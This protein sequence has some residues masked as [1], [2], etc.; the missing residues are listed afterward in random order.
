MLG[1]PKD[2][3]NRYK[4]LFD[5][6]AN[7]EETGIIL[8]SMLGSSETS[9]SKWKCDPCSSTFANRT[10]Y[11]DHRRLKHSNAAGGRSLAKPNENAQKVWKCAHCSAGFRTKTLKL[12]HEGEQ[13]PL[14]VN[15]SSNN[16]VMTPMNVYPPVSKVRIAN[17]PSI[18]IHDDDSDN[19]DAFFPNI[20]EVNIDVDDENEI[21]FADQEPEMDLGLYMLQKHSQISGFDPLE[22]NNSNNSLLIPMHVYPSASKDEIIDDFNSKWKCRVCS[23]KFRTRDLLREHN[24]VHMVE[25]RNVKPCPKPNPKP[26]PKPSPKQLTKIKVKKFDNVTDGTASDKKPVV[27]DE[28]V[29]QDPKSRW[30]CK[31]CSLFFETR[32][33]LRIHRRNYFAKSESTE[34]KEELVE[35]PIKEEK[36]VLPEVRKVYPG[37]KKRKIEQPTV[38]YE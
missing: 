24:H 20:A 12:K 8:Q 9:P 21:V 29:L 34:V 10:Q 33:L 19:D 35:A 7:I 1:Q 32:E 18:L 26:S 17:E 25:K 6:E 4:Q 28:V 36:Q 22:V 37:A 30:Q 31:T 14:E 23:G 5:V 3:V 15:N 27:D 38:Q 16:S 11:R 2:T 13:H